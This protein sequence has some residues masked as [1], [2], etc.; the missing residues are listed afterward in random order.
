MNQILWERFSDASLFGFALVLS[1]TISQMISRLRDQLRSDEHFYDEF[2]QVRNLI[3][4][5][6]VTP[7][8]LFTTATFLLPVWQADN[9][10]LWFCFLAGASILLAQALYAAGDALCC[11]IIFSE[12]V[13]LTPG[14]ISVPMGSNARARVPDIE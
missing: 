5:F 13:P 1:L 11:R 2:R 4:V 8:V 6:G 3:L 14:P 12:G 9:L 7:Y 10:F